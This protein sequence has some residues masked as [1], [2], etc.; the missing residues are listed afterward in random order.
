MY[1][2]HS[3]KDDHIVFLSWKLWKEK[4]ESFFVK[5]EK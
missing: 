5:T 1:Q 4:S 2:V 3:C